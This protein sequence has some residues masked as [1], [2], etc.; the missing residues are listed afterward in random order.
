LNVSL[1]FQEIDIDLPTIIV[2]WLGK[3]YENKKK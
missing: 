3:K 1:Q 2:R